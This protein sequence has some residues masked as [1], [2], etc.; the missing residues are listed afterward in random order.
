MNAFGASAGKLY[1]NPQ[2]GLST[3]FLQFDEGARLELM[4]RPDMDSLEPS[5][6]RAGYA[7]LAFNMGSK[8]EVIRQ[9]EHLCEMGCTLVSG[10]R[11]T[12]DGYFESLLLDPE[13]NLIEIT[14]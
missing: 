4:H 6:L 10:P 9:T 7:H 14:V 5:P 2:T 13:K 3:Y 8:E 12:G 1:H 11:T